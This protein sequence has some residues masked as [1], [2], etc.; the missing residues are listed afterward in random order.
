MAVLVGLF[1]LMLQVLAFEAYLNI[2]DEGIILVG[3]Q[4]VMQGELPYRDFW[5]MY[6][7]GQFYLAGW[8]LSAF[9]SSALAVRAVGLVAK[10][11]ITSLCYLIAVRQAPR[12]WALVAALVVLLLLVAVR[13]DTFPI[14][15]ALAFALAAIWMVDRPGPGRW[16]VFLAGVLT[17]GV[18]L[19]RHD[20]GAYSAV[21]IVMALALRHAGRGAK[22]GQWMAAV[23]R[24]VFFYLVGMA[25][26]I[27]PVFGWMLVS[28]PLADLH[29]SLIRTP[30][31][32]YPE[33]RRLPFPGLAQWPREWGRIGDVGLFVVYAPFI[34]AAW[35]ACVEW[36]RRSMDRGAAAADGLGHGHGSI[37]LP[38]LVI[39]CLLFT[40]KGLV[41]VSAVHMV[42]ALVLST[43]V[44]VVAAQV[45]VAGRSRSRLWLA[46][47]LVVV[48]L[49]AQPVWVGVR[50]VVSGA[51][52]FAGREGSLL[53][54]CR[55]PPLPRLRCVSGDPHYLEAAR[56]LLAHSQP[57]D[58]IYVG[59]QRHDKIFI[60]GV[61]FYFIAQRLPVTKW[62]ELHPGIQTRPD[63][64]RAMILEMKESPPKWV[65]LDDR[66]DHIREPNASGTPSGV[67]LL[68]EYLQAGFREVE[69]FGSVR[70]LAPR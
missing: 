21:G 28:V 41:R 22:A 53:Q 3:A 20:L 62:H 36:R 48:L 18:A 27:T 30:S 65:V 4:R 24:P 49:L 13:N 9:D 51:Q 69:R 40:L 70:L 55:E 50:H 23:A 29:E 2:Y 60:S 16:P 12:S 34:A 67:V 39:T 47:V 44:L 26:V 7:P 59:T 63:V 68:D 15:P 31:V 64:Q 46:P 43:L 54:L 37:V 42:Q 61:A 45:I 14:F 66:W 10:A 58:R 1:A 56:F 6:G 17:G 38:A 57:S 19:F 35:G 11:A 33:A 25:L 32:V 52:Q 8:L 5:T